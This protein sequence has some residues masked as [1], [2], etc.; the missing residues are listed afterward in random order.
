M[1]EKTAL[2]VSGIKTVRS[3]LGLSSVRIGIE[4]N[5][6]AA[7]AALAAAFKE[8]ATVTVR[9]LPTRYPQGAEKMLAAA[10]TGRR[11][12]VGKLPS[13]VGL[14]VMNVTSVAFLAE[15]LETGLP[16][17]KKNITV[18]GNAVRTPKNIEV[19]IGTPLQDVFDFA[20]GFSLEPA[21]IIMGGPMMG[22]A[23][24]SLATSVV[25][26]TNALLA[27]DQ[28]MAKEDSASACIRCGRCAKSCPMNLLP[29]ELGKASLQGRN[30]DLKILDVNS[31]IEC[32][33]CRFVCPANIQL[34]QL[35]RLGKANLRMAI[36]KKG[37]V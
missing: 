7:V 34:V 11:I 1:M 24:H 3:V 20:G 15:F 16:L 12:P 36:T 30:D 8:D 17:V 19:P 22:V 32:G 31:C 29:M 27:F 13:D 5:K 2:V 25:K 9:A 14:V 21:K 33:C 10:L 28:T 35:M 6:P 18:D 4:D 26:H 23:Q 37:A